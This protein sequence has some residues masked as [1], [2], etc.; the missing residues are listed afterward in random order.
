MDTR[1]IAGKMRNCCL[2]HKEII[3]KRIA[4]TLLLDHTER[5]QADETFRLVYMLL[6]STAILQLN[7]MT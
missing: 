6:L 1:G 5:N 7:N 2:S 3:L 4:K